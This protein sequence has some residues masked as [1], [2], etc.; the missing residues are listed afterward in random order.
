MGQTKRA[1]R[2]NYGIVRSI[3]PDVCWTPIGGVMLPI[4]YRIESDMRFARGTVG[5]VKQKG[6]ETFTMDSFTSKVT[7]NEAGTGGGILSGVNLGTCRAATHCGL[8]LS[9][10]AYVI[11]H[12]SQFWMNCAGPLGQPNTVGKLVLVNIK[13]TVREFD[14]TIQD[15]KEA[16]KTLTEKYP[17][18]PLTDADYQRAADQLGVDKNV[19]RAI[20][21]QESPMG[22]M[23]PSG[24]ATVLFEGHHFY[25]N[26]LNNAVRG[27]T[28]QAARLARQ[29]ALTQLQ[30]WMTSH[31]SLVY[32]N[33][34]T[35]HY[36][37]N[38]EREL[39]ER[40]GGAIALDREAALMSTSFG[41]FQILGSNYRAAGFANVEDF[42]TAMNS[43]EAAQLQ[44]FVNFTRNSDAA[45]L[46]A[47]KARDWNTIALRY[48]GPR[49]LEPGPDGKNYADKLKAHYEKLEKEDAAKQKGIHVE[50]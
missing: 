33:W 29:T 2:A 6:Q 42:V 8:V 35:A 3:L 49:A 46:N 47:M 37:A 38:N 32:R 28:G 16:A 44:A 39:A 17:K 40:V 20:A 13:G 45:L 15:F 43:G 5:N 18:A 1:A 25:R 27:L 48:N 21:E 12:T 30:S 4:P 10:R 7:G 26:Y 23:L 24:N 34:T 36:F 11:Q 9:R 31:P 19:I 22:G 41:R 14:I 50:R